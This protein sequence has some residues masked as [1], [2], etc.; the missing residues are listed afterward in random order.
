MM[1]VKEG[2][3]NRLGQCY[4]LAGHCVCVI[5]DH[6][7]AMLVHGTINGKFFTGID[8]DNPHAWVEENGEVFDP[9]WNR[10]FSKETYYLLVNA[11][12]I[13]TYDHEAALKNMFVFE[14]WGP[15]P[16]EGEME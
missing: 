14:H 16:K 2:I 8:F 9:V 12:V 11:K 6:P 7:N 10:W 3:K 13:S 5:D 1:E 15:W 4:V